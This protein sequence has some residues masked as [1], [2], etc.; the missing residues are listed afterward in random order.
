[1]WSP[2]KKIVAKSITCEAAKRN[3]ELN[4][5]SSFP[6]I[7]LDMPVF[8][9]LFSNYF[10]RLSHALLTHDVTSACTH[11]CKLFTRMRHNDHFR[12][13]LLHYD[14]WFS[15]HIS[16]TRGRCEATSG[17]GQTQ[18]L[19]KHAICSFLIV[20][21]DLCNLIFFLTS[22]WRFSASLNLSYSLC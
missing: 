19:S 22:N 9:M 3:F 4:S 16:R 13:A 18:L 10:L 5:I 21:W 6:F 17:P 12:K 8:R 20:F 2:A 1:M 14:D 7:L 15:S 11:V